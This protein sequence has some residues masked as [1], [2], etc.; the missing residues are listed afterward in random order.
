MFAFYSLLMQKRDKELISDN[1]LY[2]YKEE[3]DYKPYLAKVQKE[4]S[5]AKLEKKEDEEIKAWVLKVI[6]KSLSYLPQERPKFE[7]IVS[8]LSQKLKSVLPYE[9][10]A[11]LERQKLLEKIAGKKKQQPKQ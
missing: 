11:Q 8:S 10:K 3:K 5:N 2:K 9:K 4:L 7:E 1:D 6:L